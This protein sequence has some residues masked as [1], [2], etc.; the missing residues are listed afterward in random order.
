MTNIKEANR[1]LA[2]DDALLYRE[3]TRIFG[4]IDTQIR[5]LSASETIELVMISIDF[6]AKI[7]K[8]FEGDNAF[9]KTMTK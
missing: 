2:L 3:R 5:L 1:K 6:S 4:N 7:S 8:I 9:Y